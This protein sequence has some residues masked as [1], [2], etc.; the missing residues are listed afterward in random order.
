MNSKD[1][2]IESLLA[3]RE[4]Q[5]VLLRYCRG[6]DRADEE[7]IASCFH[8]DACDDHGN[9]LA[10]GRSVA[11]HIVRAIK[12]GSA[13]AMHFMGNALVEVEGDKA[14]A[15]SYILA[16]RADDREGVPHT[17]TRAVRFV[18]RFERRAGEWRISERV[19]VDEWSRVDRVFESQDGASQFRYGAK[20]RSDPVY[21]IRQGP[22]ARTELK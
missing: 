7:L 1:Q 17:R 18:D 11:S 13:R 3:E 8:P 21:L 2:I 19:V 10:D 20:D 9:W 4:I 14:F 16:F 5:R 6:V 12:P 22:L 15:E